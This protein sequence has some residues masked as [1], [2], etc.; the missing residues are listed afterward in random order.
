MRVF[1][2]ALQRLPLCQEH[3]LAHMLIVYLSRTEKL[4]WGL[5]EEKWADYP[6]W[7]S[8]WINSVFNARSPHELGLRLLELERAV[9][10]RARTTAWYVITISL[11]LSFSYDRIPR[12]AKY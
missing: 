12:M 7:R 10:R 5:L 3:P 8:R 11:S 2:Y 9:Q 4:L 1:V 6:A